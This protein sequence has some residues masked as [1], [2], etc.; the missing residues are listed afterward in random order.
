MCDLLTRTPSQIDEIDEVIIMGAPGLAGGPGRVAV[1]TAAAMPSTPLNCGAKA[2]L[3]TAL[4]TNTSQMDM[5][6]GVVGWFLLGGVFVLCVIGRAHGFYRW[7]HRAAVARVLA[8]RRAVHRIV[9][10]YRV[11]CAQIDTKNSH[12]HNSLPRPTSNP[13]GGRQI[14]A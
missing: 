10:F 9:L 1:A 6:I 2:L 4:E 13:R 3:R 14:D 11:C 8:M 7:G 5:E 12:T